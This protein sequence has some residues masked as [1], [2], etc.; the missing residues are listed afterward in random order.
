VE[1]NIKSQGFFDSDAG[2]LITDG[3]DSER[4]QGNE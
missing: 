4:E 1:Q 2:M 3:V